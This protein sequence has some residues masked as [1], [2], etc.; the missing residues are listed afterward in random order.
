MKPALVLAVVAVLGFAT[1]AQAEEARNDTSLEVGLLA[2]YV[3]NK[4]RFTGAGIVA[5]SIVPGTTPAPFA[6]GTD[7]VSTG[8]FAFSGQV[9]ALTPYYGAGI[10]RAFFLAGATVFVSRSA[11]STFGSFHPGGQPDTG[12]TL[13]RAFA[14]DLALGGNFPLCSTPSCTDLRGFVGASVVRQT[15]TGFTDETTDGGKREEI[16]ESAFKW[17]P[18]FGATFTIPLCGNCTS[19]SL[20]LQLGAIVRAIQSTSLGFVTATG[21]I[22]ALGIDSAFETQLH[23]GLL[24]PL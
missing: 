18:L 13:S 22:Y 11:T 15:A 9:T 19:E 10:F 2:G 5:S 3:P 14:V 7:S 23:A 6:T 8:G 21:R 24:L 12:V 4:S 20:R 1:N 16:T 17:G